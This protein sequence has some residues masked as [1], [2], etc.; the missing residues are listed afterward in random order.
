MNEQERLR[1]LYRLLLG[2][3]PVFL[4]SHPTSRYLNVQHVVIL[5]G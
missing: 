4:S 1:F 5:L 2:S 3:N